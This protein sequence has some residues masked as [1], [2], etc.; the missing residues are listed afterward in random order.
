MKKN[1]D[2][3][4]AFLETLDLS[5]FE[6]KQTTQQ[7]DEYDV[8]AMLSFLADRYYLNC[9]ILGQVTENDLPGHLLR[10]Q[11]TF[12]KATLAEICK[13]IEET[14][15]G[16]GILYHRDVPVDI[17]PG[18]VQVSYELLHPQNDSNSRLVIRDTRDMLR[19]LHEEHTY[20]P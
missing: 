1:P 3:I 18:H 14:L 5:G 15:D 11:F 12:Q 9:F 7:A 2:G 4:D 10:G 20:R 16:L 8:R 17:G 13:K 6:G 19:N